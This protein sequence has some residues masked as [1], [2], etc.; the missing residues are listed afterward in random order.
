MEAG[1]VA[2]LHNI[3]RNHPLVSSSGRDFNKYL[4]IH[5]L[6]SR[7]KRRPHGRRRPAP[8]SESESARKT[9][10]GDMLRGPQTHPSCYFMAIAAGAVGLVER[11]GDANRPLFRF[12]ADPRN[13]AD[14]NYVIIIILDRKYHVSCGAEARMEFAGRPRGPHK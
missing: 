9:G 1:D 5:I 2:A 7:P 11:G 8:T 14:K 4:S 10:L 12:V 3:R 6:C 13:H